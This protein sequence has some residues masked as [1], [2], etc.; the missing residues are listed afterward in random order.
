MTITSLAHLIFGIGVDMHKHELREINDKLDIILAYIKNIQKKENTMSTLIDDLTAKT[1]AL[2]ADV[3]ANGD[4]VQSAVLAI[5]GLTDQQAILSKQLA[6]AIASNDPT[7]I[8]AAA[9]AIAAQNDLIVSQTQALAAA[10]PA[11]TP[12]A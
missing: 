10:I 9:D 11:N 6:D 7:A 3:K 8:Q 1:A 5:K 12:A 2:V 4:V